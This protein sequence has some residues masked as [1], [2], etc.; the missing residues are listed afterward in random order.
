[1]SLV[2]FESGALAR[3]NIYIENTTTGMVIDSHVPFAHM[4]TLHVYVCLFT[5]R[6]LRLPS[7]RRLRADGRNGTRTLYTVNIHFVP[8]ITC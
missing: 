8:L 3:R 1:M 2:V 6:V 7:P 5:T 4:Q